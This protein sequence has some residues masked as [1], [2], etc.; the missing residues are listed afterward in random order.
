MFNLLFV[1]LLLFVLY[2]VGV[3]YCAVA[4]VALG[5]DLRRLVFRLK[6]VVGVIIFRTTEN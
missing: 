2:V 5:T 1:L 4:S 3:V 6:F